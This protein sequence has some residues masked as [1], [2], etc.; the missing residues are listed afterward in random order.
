[1]ALFRWCVTFEFDEQAPETVRGEIV[2]GKAETAA[3]RAIKAAKKERP[4]TR[5]RSIVVLLEPEAA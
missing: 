5:A 1:M 2:A 4:N 3:H